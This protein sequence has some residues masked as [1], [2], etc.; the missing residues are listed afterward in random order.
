VAAPL[1]LSVGSPGFRRWGVGNFWRVANFQAALF[2]HAPP[3][4]GGTPNEALRPP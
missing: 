1:A 2:W 4:E 3:P